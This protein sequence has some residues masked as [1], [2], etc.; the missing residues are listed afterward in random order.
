MA[1]A[2][3]YAQ[4]TRFEAATE[5][6]TVRNTYAGMSNLAALVAVDQAV[7]GFGGLENGISR[8]LEHAA[9]DGVD[10]TALSAGLGERWELAHG[11]FKIHAAS[12]HS[13]SAGRRRNFPGR[14]GPNH[15]RVDPRRNLPSGRAADGVAA[16]EP[17]AGEVLDPVCGRDGA[18]SWRHRTSGVHKRGDN[19][20]S[21]GA[22]R[23][24][25]RCCRRRNRRSGSREERRASDHRN[26]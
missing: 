7:A 16:A 5:G 26:I 24:R 18:A 9:A 23:A 6:A 14:T 17:A 25:Y 21:G 10:E 12:V 11:Y 19:S 15:S 4:H 2:A 1:I 13:S 3:N 8:H 22:R 20:R